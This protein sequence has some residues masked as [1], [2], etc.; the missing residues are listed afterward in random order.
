M[1]SM[2]VVAFRCPTCGVEQTLLRSDG[3]RF[4]LN[5]QISRRRTAAGLPANGRAGSTPSN[6]A[7]RP[8]D[9]AA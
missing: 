3:R 9:S 1:Y 7:A 8:F 2:S 6:Q 4:C 5:C